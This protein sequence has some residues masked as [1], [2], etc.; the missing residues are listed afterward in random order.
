MNS[1][2]IFRRDFRIVDNTALNYC[3]K[4]SDKIYPIFIFT[5]EQIKNN[6][7]KS[8]NAIQ[9]MIESLKELDNEIKVSF[10]YGNYIDVIKSLIKSKK[11]NSIHANTDYTKYGIKRDKDIHKICKKYEIKLHLYHDICLQPPNSVLNKSKQIY[12]KFTP[13]YNTH[14]RIKVRNPVRLKMKKNKFSHIKSKY[15]LK[16][17]SI[18]KFYKENPNISVRGGRK[19]ALKITGSIRDFSTYEKTRDTLSL[20]TT[21]LSAYLKFG[22]LSIREVYYILKKKFNIKHPLIRQLIW[23]D[24]YYHLGYGFIERFGKSLKP[25]YDNIKWNYNT[26]QFN[27]WCNGETG[28]PIVDACMKEINTTGYM[29]NR[30]RLIVSSFLVKNLQIDWRKGEKY[31]AQSLVDYDV[32]VNNGNWQWTSGSGADSQPYFRVFRPKLQSEKHDKDCKYIKKW[33]PNLINIPNKDLHNWDIKYTEYDVKKI[34]YYKPI[35]EYKES[36]DAA[37][38]MYKK[39]LK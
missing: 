9:F 11:I 3:Y 8:N 28:Y 32:L 26:S 27:K 35:I 29:H 23:R 17:S 20:E 36:R 10:F 13:Y 16:N 5:P 31:F 33:L 6:P 39:A 19:N 22:C 34:K 1:L 4:N 2:F 18:N 7:F 14:L 12:Q 30:G 21:R 24:F 38:K 37:L 25:K 15:S